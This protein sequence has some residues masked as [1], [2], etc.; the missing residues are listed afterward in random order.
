MGGPADFCIMFQPQMTRIHSP[1][2]S[3]QREPEGNTMQCK[4]EPNDLDR[5]QTASRDGLSSVSAAVLAVRLTRNRS[6]RSAHTLGNSVPTCL[7]S[8]CSP[9]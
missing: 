6:V 5:V 2:S 1:L 3:S 7:Y 8:T 9:T 4:A